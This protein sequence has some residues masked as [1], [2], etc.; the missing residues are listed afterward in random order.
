MTKFWLL[1]R[2]QINLNIGDNDNDQR[3]TSDS[4]GD[5]KSDN[6]TLLTGSAE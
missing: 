1:N 6:E 4:S 2:F 3:Y 5:V